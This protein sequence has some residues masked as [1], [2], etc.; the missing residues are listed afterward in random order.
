[1]ESHNGSQFAVRQS[2]TRHILADMLEDEY[3]KNNDLF[4]LEHMMIE[5]FILQK[6]TMEIISPRIHLQTTMSRLM[7]GDS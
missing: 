4:D 7:A 5:A 6:N 3:D 1:M 2:L